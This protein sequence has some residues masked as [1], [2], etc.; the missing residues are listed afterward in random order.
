MSIY[1]Y[2]YII[3]DNKK[4]YYDPVI[5]DSLLNRF[6]IQYNSDEDIIEFNFPDICHHDYINFDNLDL[7]SSYNNLYENIKNYPEPLSIIYKTDIISDML[8]SLKYININKSNNDRTKV[9]V[10][11]NFISENNKYIQFTLTNFP[12]GNILDQNKLVGI[13]MGHS[14]IHMIKGH[15]CNYCCIKWLIKTLEQISELNET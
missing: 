5:N 8:E 15:A 7:Y 14:K 4:N 1:N 3:N 11:K 13:R 10:S 12:K 9:M 2:E 6:S